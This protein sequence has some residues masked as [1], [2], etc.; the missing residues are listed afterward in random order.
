M[1]LCCCCCRE[2]RFLCQCRC[3]LRPDLI[4]RSGVAEKARG[5]TRAQRSPDGRQQLSNA[6]R[7]DGTTINV[8]AAAAVIGVV[9]AAA[10][11]VGRAQPPLPCCSGKGLVSEGEGRAETTERRGGGRHSADAGACSAVRAAAATASAPSARVRSPGVIAAAATAVI[12]APAAAAA[13]SICCSVVTV[14]GAVVEEEVRVASIAQRFGKEAAWEHVTSIEMMAL[15]VAVATKMTTDR[16]ARITGLPIGQHSRQRERCGK[17]KVWIAVTSSRG[18]S[19][20]VAGNTGLPP[21][22]STGTRATSV[23]SSRGITANVSSHSVLL[24]SSCSGGCGVAQARVLDQVQADGENSS[25]HR[26]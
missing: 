13:A 14:V 22:V 24:A 11:R 15:A 16:G 21:R 17:D 7:E 2:R 3:C 1:R 4:Q 26:L 12:C 20:G 23:S 25:S 5:Q 19:L 9:V 18:G 10:S 8:A 6:R